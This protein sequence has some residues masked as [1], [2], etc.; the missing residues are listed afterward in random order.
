[1]PISVQL[2]LAE[3]LIEVPFVRDDL[4][5][6]ERSTSRC[7]DEA[8]MSIVA[9]ERRVRKKLA[10]Q[11]LLEY[12][13]LNFFTARDAPVTRS[14]EDGALLKVEIQKGRKDYHEK[15]LFERLQLIADEHCTAPL[16][17]LKRSLRRE[18]NEGM[19]DG[20]EYRQEFYPVTSPDASVSLA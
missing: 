19:P 14:V 11:N 10:S 9:I 6:W 3:G 5:A 18:P 8:S 12:D 1:M 2:P 15:D 4:Q 20:W 16:L 7:L 13:V 17:S